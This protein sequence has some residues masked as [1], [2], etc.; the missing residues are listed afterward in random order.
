[1]LEDYISRNIVLNTSKDEL[2]E[3]MKADDKVRKKLVKSA[4]TMQK[5]IGVVASFFDKITHQIGNIPNNIIISNN[6]SYLFA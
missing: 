3:L 1:M 5:R 4:E 2:L 6:R